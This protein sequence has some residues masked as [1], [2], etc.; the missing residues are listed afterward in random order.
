MPAGVT[1]GGVWL[2]GEID[3]KCQLYVLINR[4]GEWLKVFVSRGV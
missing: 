3:L 4:V 2:G 1:K